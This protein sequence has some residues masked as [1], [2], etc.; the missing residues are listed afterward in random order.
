[1]NRRKELLIGWTLTAIGLV[2]LA[3]SIIGMYVYFK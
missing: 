2:M 1:M 3:Y